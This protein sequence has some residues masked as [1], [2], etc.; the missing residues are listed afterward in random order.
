MRSWT[1]TGQPMS[2]FP[3][4]LIAQNF[5]RD[6]DGQ[7]LV[8]HQLWDKLIINHGDTLI[9]GKYPYLEVERKKDIA[10]TKIST[11]VEP[12]DANPRPEQREQVMSL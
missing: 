12:V 2:E 4:W 10:L 6:A 9:L 3:A 8:I 1:F 5:A 7:F 11:Y